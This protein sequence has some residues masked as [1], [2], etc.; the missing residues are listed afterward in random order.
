MSNLSLNW[1]LLLL[2]GRTEC[3]YSDTKTAS[4]ETSAHRWIVA[5]LQQSFLGVAR[6]SER[7]CEHCDV[8]RSAPHRGRGG[9]APTHPGAPA[10]RTTAMPQTEG[11]SRI[12]PRIRPLNWP[13]SIGRSS[14]GCRS[15][16]VVVIRCR[17]LSSSVGRPF[18]VVVAV[19]GHRL[20][21]VV[22]RPSSFVVVVR[23]RPSTVVCRGSR[24]LSSSV[25]LPCRRRRSSSSVVRRPLS[26][27]S[28]SVVCSRP[29]CRPSSVVALVRRPSSPLPS[30]IVHCPSSVVV[31]R[32][33]SAVVVFVVVRRF[34]RRV[35]FG[36]RRSSSVVG[37]RRLSHRC[38]ETPG[39][40]RG[41]RPSARVSHLSCVRRASPEPHSAA[42]LSHLHFP[43]PPRGAL[44]S[45]E[46]APRLD[47][48]RPASG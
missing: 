28:S 27:S 43:R 31:C 45:A 33:S 16:S 42:L 44:S 6:R 7:R 37:P 47:Q 14:V 20:S 18:V 12:S 13:C 17:C 5:W 29:Q 23:R 4:G 46:L 24:R 3:A 34:R 22:R 30:S 41:M 35:V 32:P 39:P 9:P 2:L 40:C 15:S 1:L 38:V 26:P 48:H 25:R 10:R 8:A 36:R 19:V 11:R 21:F